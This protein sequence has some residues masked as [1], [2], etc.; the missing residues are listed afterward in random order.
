MQPALSLGRAPA[1]QAPAALEDLSE[2]QYSVG[3][4]KKLS[5]FLD[6][7]SGPQPGAFAAPREHRAI[8]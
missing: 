8:S 5:I 7:A 4:G 3:L 1:M 6:Q 2:K